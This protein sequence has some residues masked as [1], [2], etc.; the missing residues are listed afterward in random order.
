[1]DYLEKY[2]LFTFGLLMQT[3]FRAADGNDYKSENE[4]NIRFKRKTVFKI[5]LP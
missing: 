1:L 5:G 3:G 2:T 4:R